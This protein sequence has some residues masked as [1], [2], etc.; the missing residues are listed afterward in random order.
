MKKNILLSLLVIL[1]P[2]LLTGCS[3]DSTAS[4][5]QPTNAVKQE[6]AQVAPVAKSKV[7][8]LPM[9]SSEAVA[10]KV[11]V[12]LF[13]ATQR[14]TTCT[15]IGRLAGETVNERFQEEL[16]SGKIEFR[17]VNI[18]LPENKALAAKFQASGSA[19]FLNPIRGNVDNI[20]QDVK[21]WR[22]TSDPDAFKSYLEGRLNIMLG[23]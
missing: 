2:L 8:D 11:Q 12:F 13:H 15:A 7:D 16:K 1:S 22:L 23:K 20:E 4:A 17:E 21:V 18:D 19:L 14:C 9:S 6:T 10:D 3:T 5:D